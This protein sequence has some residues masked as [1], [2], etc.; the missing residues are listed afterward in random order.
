VGEVGVVAGGGPQGKELGLARE[1]DYIH[2]EKV[3]IKT[4]PTLRRNDGLGAPALADP[5]D[6]RLLASGTG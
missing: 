1:G 4:R 5:G 6:L 2:P 3:F